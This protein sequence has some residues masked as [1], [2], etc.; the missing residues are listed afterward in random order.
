MLRSESLTLDAQSRAL[1]ERFVPA[2][3]PLRQFDDV[4]DFS[5]VLPLVAERYHDEIGRPA[6]HPERLWRLLFAQYY[7][8]LSD[9]KVCLAAHESL[10]LRLFLRLGI[11]EAPPHPTTLQKFRANRLDADVYLKIHFELLRQ[12]EARRLLR[13]EERQIFDT[14]HVRSNTR[15]V[16]LPRLLLEARAKVVK[17]VAKVDA[18]YGAELAAQAEADYQTYRAER[19][20][21]KLEDLPKPT[22]DEKVEAA[23][24]PVRRTPDDVQARIR[25]GRV[26][27]TE[28]INVAVAILAKVIADREDGATERIVSVHDPEARKGKKTG[29]TWDGRKLAVNVT[30]QSYFIVAALS[31][32]ANDNDQEFV[33][34][35]LDQEQGQLQLV[36]PELIA[37]KAA[38]F[39]PLREQIAQRGILAQIPVAPAPNAKGT[40]LFRSDDFTYDPEQQALTCPAHQ[41]ATHPK[42]EKVQS[43]DGYRFNFSRRVCRACP[44]N[45]RCQPQASGTT[46]RH[47]GRAVTISVHWRT[48]QA[49]KQHL[50]TASFQT[51]YRRRGRIEPKI[52]ELIYHGQRRC[53]YRGDARSQCQLLITVAVVNGKRLTRLIDQ[54]VHPPRPRRRRF[55]L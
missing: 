25:S 9:E 34:P 35:L 31:A 38:D 49:A 48:A 44:L 28:R 39:D 22:K 53:R 18:E 46:A 21:R 14:S 4:L 54:R 32:P 24:R 36:P 29:R 6:E 42:R 3:H 12:A 16:S 45:P 40:S 47:E 19:E 1:Y 10:A 8:N 52:W 37:D 17:E 27:P 20:R 30:D 41:V 5:F 26:V 7:L 13:R 43:R 50:Q 33:L 23:R 2:S 11:D 51:A 55:L 15:V